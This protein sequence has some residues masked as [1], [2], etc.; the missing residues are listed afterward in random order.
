MATNSY[1]SFSTSVTP[2][3]Y[4]TAATSTSFSA[5]VLNRPIFNDPIVTRCA[6]QGH[7]MHLECELEDGAFAGVCSQCGELIKGRRI[8]GGFAL[9]KLRLALEQVMCSDKEIVAEEFLRLAEEVDAEEK[10]LQEARSLL[11]LAER[12]LIARSTV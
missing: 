3:I 8:A 6:R 11:R 4:S 7:E 2:A 1:G 9:A 10:A 5:D 12:A